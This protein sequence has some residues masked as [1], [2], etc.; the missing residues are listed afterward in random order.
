MDDNPSSDD[1]HPMLFYCHSQPRCFF[2]II[3]Y[4]AFYLYAFLLALLNPDPDLSKA[5]GAV[6]IICSQAEQ[7]TNFTL[8]NLI[9]SK[10]MY[11]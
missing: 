6:L 9:R 11:I 4:Y 5:R 1:I 2:V 7:G 10:M 3:C 8:A